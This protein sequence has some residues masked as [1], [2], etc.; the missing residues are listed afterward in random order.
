MARKPS[1]FIPGTEL[2]R[3]HS[4]K[5]DEYFQPEKP[6]I[7]SSHRP[8]ASPATPWLKGTEQP[9]IIER[10]VL[11]SPN[12]ESR[13]QIPPEAFR[14]RDQPTT[15]QPRYLGV[16]DHCL[17]GHSSIVAVSRVSQQPS[18]ESYDSSLSAASWASSNDPEV[19]NIYMSNERTTFQ[20]TQVGYFENAGNKPDDTRQ[21]RHSQVTHGKAG[22]QPAQM[23]DANEAGPSSRSTEQREMGGSFRKETI[24]ST[25]SDSRKSNSNLRPK[26]GLKFIGSGRES[27]SDEKS[28]SPVGGRNFKGL[29]K[30]AFHSLRIDKVKKEKNVSEKQESLQTPS[31]EIDPVYHLLRCAANKSQSATTS[32]VSTDKPGEK[33]KSN[34]ETSPAKE[35]TRQLAVA[36]KKRTSTVTF[37]SNNPLLESPECSKSLKPPE[38]DGMG[39]AA[40]LQR[41]PQH[42]HYRINSVKPDLIVGTNEDDFRS[43]EALLAYAD[44]PTLEN[45]YSLDVDSQCNARN[46]VSRMLTQPIKEEP[47]LH[48]QQRMPLAYRLKSFSTEDKTEPDNYLYPERHPPTHHSD[49]VR[50]DTMMTSASSGGSR[51]RISNNMECHV[52]RF[53]ERTSHAIPRGRKLLSGK[54]FSLDIPVT[55]EVR[56]EVHV[57]SGSSSPG[58]DTQI[59]SHHSTHSSRSTS[60]RTILTSQRNDPSVRFMQQISPNCSRPRIVSCMPPELHRSA[61]FYTHEWQ[62]NMASGMTSTKSCHR[63]VQ[64]QALPEFPKLSQGDAP[65]SYTSSAPVR[66]HRLPNIP[67]QGNVLEE[68]TVFCVAREYIPRRSDEIRL[69]LGQYVKIIDDTDPVWWYGTCN[70]DLGYFPSSYLQ[71]F[72]HT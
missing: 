32:A 46:E 62:E 3:Q 34:E 57:V 45:E 4:I 42:P 67:P 11:N 72:R 18:F 49:Y 27:T 66:S 40:A 63:L 2:K 7:P 58:R 61:P 16:V 69:R 1:P 33:L 65:T 36:S 19:T 37:K 44:A 21:E 24:T 52:P 31:G 26:Q 30:R 38:G 51:T 54:S 41:S 9:R 55:G 47:Y 43:E 20:N 39:P 53:K 14:T 22:K 70:G 35:S 8:T 5:S 64:Q 25:E 17:S 6:G 71:R 56:D 68:D 15:Q 60:R 48:Q 28:N 13:V 23:S 10:V 12:L 29:W 50:G 59:E